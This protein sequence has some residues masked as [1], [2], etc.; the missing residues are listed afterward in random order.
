M[1][2]ILVG[3]GRAGAELANRLARAGHSVTVIDVDP[4]AFDNLATDF[5]GHIIEAE[6]LNRDV[7][8]NAGVAEADCVA[9]LTNADA[10]NAVV[11]HIA[12]TVY[13]VPRVV[14][15]NYDPRWAPLHEAFGIPTVNSVQWN[16]GRFEELLALTP[17]PAL[18]QLG[19]GEVAIYELTVPASWAGRSL[20][21][22][23][24]GGQVVVAGVTRAGR[25]RLPAP[26][27]T[28]EIGDLI[29]LSATAEGAA[30]VC[31][32]LEGGC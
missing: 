9:T 17:M 29:V 3:C 31:A 21:E 32:R 24:E 20:G 14:A 8:A 18:R 11:A 23:T 22:L 13:N 6:V 2:A 25:S 28:L 26:D 19:D 1:H 15:R 10:L 16:A 30:Q 5:R 12:R 27:L 7:L 4:K